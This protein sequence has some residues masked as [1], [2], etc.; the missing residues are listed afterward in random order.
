MRVQQSI[1]AV[2]LIM[3]RQ[4]CP[5]CNEDVRQLTRH[6]KEKHNPDIA[7][8]FID[9]HLKGIW[10]LCKCGCRLKLKFH[11]WPRGFDGAYLRGHGTSATTE[12]APDEF[13]RCPIC[14]FTNASSSVIARHIKGQHGMTELDAC[15]KHMHDGT[16]PLCGCGCGEKLRW[17]GWAHGGFDTFLRGHSSTATKP[18]KSPKKHLT[19]QVCG[20]ESKRAQAVNNHIKK[21]HP[22]TDTERLCVKHHHDGK[23]PLCKCG[24]KQE[25]TWHGWT[26]GFAGFILGHCASVMSKESKQNRR[27]TLREGYKSGR[28][29]VWSKGKTK[30]TD[31][32]L[33]RAGIK[34][35]KTLK[36]GFRSGRL[37]VWSKGLTKETDGRL[38][39]Y[40]ERQAARFARGELVPWAKGKTKETDAGVAAM[41]ETMSGVMR[42]KKRRNRMAFYKSLGLSQQEAESRL[43]G[44]LH[45]LCY[46]DA[47]L[48]K[49]WRH[50]ILE[51][52]G[53][54]CRHCGSEAALHV[55]HD[56]VFMVTIINNV[57]A[58]RDASLMQ[59][60]ELFGVIDDV[61]S[62]HIDNDVS[63]I[64]LC[65]E[66]HTK[67]HA[68][69][70][71]EADTLKQAV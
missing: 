45:T 3:V 33:A 59:E 36:K 24:C 55:H 62:Y 40:S 56:R 1:A 19:C 28:I 50:P 63:G 54:R 5:I 2:C 68:R 18:T 38:T 37:K 25:T 26:Y 32:R 12:K 22:E 41:A 11:S 4:A 71:A 39:A 64:T 70:A 67:E 48:G 53:R 57:L 44:R 30:E 27:Q 10:P 61:V 23:H 42:K 7:Q 9:L 60:D 58:R 66:C 13:K 65:R 8:A 43:S 35:S 49:Q 31:E 20:F 21:R 6:I 29:E 14:P 51:R 16:H 69:I 34:R 15:I 47:R 17:L 52:D 46:R